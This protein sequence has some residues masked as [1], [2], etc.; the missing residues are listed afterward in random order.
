MLRRVQ[1]RRACVGVQSARC[2]Y[3][4]Q[5]RYAVASRLHTHTHTHTLSL[6]LLRNCFDCVLPCLFPCL[7]IIFFPFAPRVMLAIMVLHLGL[8]L[9][10][11]VL[12]STSTFCFRFH[13]RLYF[14][15]FSLTILHLHIWLI[16]LHVTVITVFFGFGLISQTDA[17]LYANEPQLTAEARWAV[18][19]KISFEMEGF[20]LRSCQKKNV[21]SP[22]FSFSSRTRAIQFTHSYFLQTTRESLSANG[23][24]VRPYDMFLQDL[25]EKAEALKGLCVCVCVCVCVLVWAFS[26]KRLRNQKWKESVHK[27]TR[28]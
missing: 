19:V 24:T 3:F 20:I 9:S 27:A 1:S 25:S 2:G 10:L 23:V 17:I 28:K 13:Y 8:A 26:E 4:L 18:L 21:S 14:S 6:S 12:H 22:R 15:I 16:Y 7:R 11:C 5:S